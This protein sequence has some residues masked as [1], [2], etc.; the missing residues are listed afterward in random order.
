[1]KIKLAFLLFLIF[2]VSGCKDDI[3]EMID[4]TL[5]TD[6]TVLFEGSLTGSGNY[7]V[8]GIVTIIEKNGQK[9]IQFENF[10]SSSGPDLKVFISNEIRPTNGI[11]LGVLKALS[12]NFSY[13][14]PATFDFDT[15]GPFVLIYCEQFTVLFGSTR[16]EPKGN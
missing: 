2:V 9:S 14:L 3:E 12:G 4:E 10:S 7:N 15:T 5:I 8:R 11:G 16:L 13:S 1:M 6:G